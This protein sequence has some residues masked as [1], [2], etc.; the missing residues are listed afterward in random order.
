MI[1]PR[2]YIVFGLSVLV[3]SLG[4]CSGL[5]QSD[6]P[7]IKRWW[8]EPYVQAAPVELVESP[9]PVTLSVTVI[10]GLDS[11][12]I[13]TLSNDAEL[14][15]FAAARWVDHLPELVSSLIGRSLQATA[16][17]EV[18]TERAASGVENC[19]LELDLREFF[20][21]IGSSGRVSGV[22]VAINGSFECDSSL[23]IVFHSASSVVV[24]D[25][26][27]TVI[28]AAF[29]QAMDDVTKD[30]FNNIY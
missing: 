8:L 3:L 2:R 14:S 25:E 27:M 5:T 12:R 15:Q 6:K 23:P 1:I 24:T 29:Q 21:D 30:I 4:A 20:A 28:V 26:R 13:L 17:F 11:D 10:P 7:A 22:R 16:Q 19:S 18:T 9:V